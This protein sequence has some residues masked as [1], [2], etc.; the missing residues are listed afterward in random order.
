MTRWQQECEVLVSNPRL[1]TWKAWVNRLWPRFCVL[2]DSQMLGDIDLCTD[3]AAAIPRN[4]K[5]CPVCAEPLAQPATRCAGCLHR[6]PYFHST[7][8]PLLYQ[9]PVDALIQQFKFQENISLANV[10]AE[11]L[12]SD[13]RERD[14]G[15]P[16]ALIP[17]PLHLTRLR[18]RGFNQALQISKSLAP[19]L[20]L[21][22]FTEALVRTRATSAQSGLDAIARRKNVRGAFVA[23]DLSK[24]DHVAIVDDV[25]STHATVNECARVLRKAGV[26]RVDVW[27]LARRPKNMRIS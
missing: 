7:V 25:M 21:P 6:A 14:V 12:L 22:I 15:M 19:R 1:S 8:A 26:A 3:C 5:A 24:I 20:D 23:N 11:F 16:Q 13:L 10:L 9:A 18:E 2:C 17:V 4:S 27:V